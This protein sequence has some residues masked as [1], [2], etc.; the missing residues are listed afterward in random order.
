MQTERVHML[1]RHPEKT[2]TPYSTC[3]MK[4]KLMITSVLLLLCLTGWTQ[5][6]FTLSGTLKDARNGED[7]IG[8]SVYVAELRTGASSNV[9]GFYSLTLPAG[10]YT[11]TVSYLGYEPVNRTVGLSG[12]LSMDF[13]LDA[14]ATELGEIVITDKSLHAHVD[15]N[16]MSSEKLNISTVKKMPAFFGEV[17]IL[18]S[19]QM[20]PGVQSA[21]EGTTGFFVRG[22]T[23]DQNLV[24]LDESTV[25][26]ASH[27]M[28]FFSVF[29]ADAVKDAELYKGG[30]PAQYGGRLA[31]LLDIR[32]K[33]GNQKEVAGVG[34]IGTIASRFTLEGPIQKDNS[35]FIVSGR[36]TYADLFLKAAPDAALRNSRLYFYDLN[37]KIN[38]RPSEKDRVMISGYFGDDVFR[39]KDLMHWSWGNRTATVRWN[40]LF[41]DRVFA[42][43]T[44]LY[45]NFNYMLG[46]KTGPADFTWKSKLA[47]I[48]IK[49]DVSYYH[50]DRHT[51]NLGVASTF[52]RFNPGH[53]TV[54]SEERVNSLV[55]D[56]KKAL[57]SA[58]YMSSDITVSEK[59]SLQPGIRYS[60][61]QNMGGRTYG[62]WN[63]DGDPMDTVVHGT[64][65]I[66]HTY[67]GLEPRFSMR[68]KLDR[69][70]S[71]KLSYNRMYQY[72]HLASN[73]TASLPLDVYI[74]SDQNIKPQIGDQ[75]AI[76]YFRNLRTNAFEFS[77]EIFY[78]DLQHQIDFRDNADLLLNNHI[79]REI[80]TGKGKAYGLELMLKKPEG[81][82][83]GWVS[84]SYSRSKRK[85]AGINNGEEYAARQDRPHAVNMVLSYPL[86]E[87]LHVGAS[88]MYASG[89][90]VT[91]PTSGYVH[92]GIVVPVYS[93]R[94]GYRLAASHRLD[95]SVTLDNKRKPG[96]KW[97]GSWNF[98]LFNAYAHKNPFSVQTRQRE[99]DPST[100]EAVQLSI[101]G[102]IIPSVTYNFKF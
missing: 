54:A 10:T 66:T 72:L 24:Q 79:D 4:T 44:A 1:M 46:S 78:K 33:E 58:V 32:M 88:W 91:I 68:Y 77:A 22:G 13:A 64:G 43:F 36:R 41:S 8:A 39:F 85:I 57:E 96:R 67:G 62:N 26:N 59:L 40:H 27:L 63:D 18:K 86:R 83:N 55:M 15:D 101:I 102:T 95:L 52:H 65:E 99:E 49:S 92:D 3:P 35:S 60:I 75:V 23:A 53:V 42:N 73:S 2:I 45:S 31:S 74:P 50:S 80:V 38:F 82:L 17:D 98:S 16:R 48:S 9:Y 71:L 69:N 37:T 90:P 20:L 29:N 28:G 51:I 97:E 11:V 84:Y 19:I 100:T 25:Y 76:G 87:R 61:F 47:D 5:T 14:V 30:I 81:K 56:N 34:G 7:L 94:N 89:M 12:D 70:S 93:A 6:K 21:G